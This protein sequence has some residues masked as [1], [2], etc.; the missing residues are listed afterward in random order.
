M[1]RMQLRVHY[2]LILEAPEGA[3][4]VL[5]A[6]LREEMTG[7]LELRVSVEVDINVADNWLVAH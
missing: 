7:G 4:G 5:A 3:L 1:I 6:M 2:E